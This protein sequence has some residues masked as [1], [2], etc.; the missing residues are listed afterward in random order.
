MVQAHD[1]VERYGDTAAVDGASFTTRPVAVTGF[2]DPNRVGTV[3][4]ML[5]IA[6]L[7]RS[8]SVVDHP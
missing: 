7:D 6:G 1:V 3:T 4:A 2:P 5:T 8:E